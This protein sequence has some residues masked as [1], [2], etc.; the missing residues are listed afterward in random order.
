MD[1]TTDSGKQNYKQHYIG[2]GQSI[3]KEVGLGVVCLLEAL[4]KVE[5]SVSKL[6]K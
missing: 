1:G 6:F 5:A 4:V 3:S 2:K